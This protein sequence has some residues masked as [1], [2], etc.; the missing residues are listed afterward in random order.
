[1]TLLT[2]PEA[3][4]LFRAPPDRHIDVGNGQVAVRSIGSGPDV[5]FVHGWPAS[6]ATFR[7][8]L[9]HLAQRMRCHVIDLVGAGDSRFDRTVRIGIA[10]HA[11]AVRRVVD[12]FDVNDIAV[13]GHDSGGLIARHALAGDP[14]VRAWGLIDTE[15]P[16]GASWRFKSFLGIRYIPR[17][18]YLLASL[19]NS[20]RMRRNRFL[21][22]DCFDNRDM[23]DGEFA[24]FFLRPLRQPDRRWAAGEFCRRFDLKALDELGE[25]HRRI[26]VP[27]Q[28]VWG[29][30]D[31][32]FPLARTREMMAGFGGP[33]QLHVFE[34][35]KLFVH[36]E[37]PN[38]TADRMLPTLVGSP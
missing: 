3:I 20:P 17:F 19:A 12:A 23:L 6:G 27:V 22:G 1:M 33:V 26:Q 36:E 13:V 35:G 2:R 38:E 4:D 28:L 32:F 10:E 15:Q 31:P 29:A 21:L 16:Q 34:R 8:L 11:E 14:R 5:L 30:R 18:E 7:G 24:E 9:P 37:F 25:L